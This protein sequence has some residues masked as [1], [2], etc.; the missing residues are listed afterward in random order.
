MHILMK[1]TVQE[2]K[3]PVKKSHPYIYDVK[4]L[5][6]LEAPYIYGI[7]RLRVK[8]FANGQNTKHTHY[9]IFTFSTALW[10]VLGRNLPFTV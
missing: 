5:T 2:V 10:S 7:S 1:C 4:F 6:L 8:V 3:S 9:N